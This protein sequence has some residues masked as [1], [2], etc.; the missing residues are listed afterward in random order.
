[1]FSNRIQL[2]TTNSGYI[3]RLHQ[4][5][6]A[7]II[8][9]LTGDIVSDVTGCSAQDVD[10]LLPQLEQDA[11][12]IQFSTNSSTSK[13]WLETAVEI[14]ASVFLLTQRTSVVL[15]NKSIGSVEHKESWSI[16]EAIT[17]TL[18]LIQPILIYHQFLNR[19]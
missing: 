3:T 19:S 6:L 14:D 12:Q 15:G 7:C 9:F 8:A 1:M 16:Q 10:T 2:H 4:E 17:K 13:V 18:R 5:R 11:K